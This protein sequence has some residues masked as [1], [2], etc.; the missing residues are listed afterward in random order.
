MLNQSQKRGHG[1]VHPINLIH[2]LFLYCKG[3]LNLSSA[4]LNPI[5]LLEDKS[6]SIDEVHKMQDLS[7]N[8]TYLS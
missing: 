8:Y 4:L 6:K 3:N 1:T 5:N 7:S 2:G